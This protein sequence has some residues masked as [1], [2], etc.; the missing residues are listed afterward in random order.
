MAEQYT[1]MQE[2][3]SVGREKKKYIFST[4]LRHKVKMFIIVFDQKP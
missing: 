4:L 3:N 1:T 2:S